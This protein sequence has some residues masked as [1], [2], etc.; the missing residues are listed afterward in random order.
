MV[1]DYELQFFVNKQT[2]LSWR[3]NQQSV[4]FRSTVHSAVYV[5]FLKIK[6]IHFYVLQN[7]YQNT[8]ITDNIRAILII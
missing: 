3:N 2:H 7:K 4:C 6:Y 1:A 5:Y 8:S